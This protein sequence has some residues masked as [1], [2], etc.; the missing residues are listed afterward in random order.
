MRLNNRSLSLCLAV[1]MLLAGC[2][3]TK[4]ASTATFSPIQPTIVF[5]GETCTYYGPQTIPAGKLTVDWI[6]KD[7]KHEA[8]GLVVATLKPDK[9][10]DDLD[11]WP[12]ADQPPWLNVVGYSEAS[13]DS[14]QQEIYQITEGPIYYVCFYRPPDTK[15]GVTRS[16]AVEG[17]SVAA[18]VPTITPHV[19]PT[20]AVQPRPV[21]IDTDMGWD[22]EVA[23]LY[24]LQRA[25]ISVQAITVSGTGL[26]H[27]NPG[28]E[29]ASG[30]ATLA[31]YADMPVACGRETPLEGAHAFPDDWRTAVDSL[32]G[33]GMNVPEGKNPAAGETA[34]SLLTAAI[35]SLP[36]KATVLLLGP[37]TNLAD[38]LQNYPQA[39]NNIEA[40]YAMGGAVHVAGN[41][42]AVVPANKA[43]EW[44][45][46]IDPHA[47]QIVFESGIPV[48]LVPL[49]ATNQV[50]VTA[51]FFPLTQAS[52]LT[53]EA[54]WVF[55]LFSAARGHLLSGGEY[56]WDPLTAAI[57]AGEGLA[58]YEQNTLCVVEQEG[59]QSGQIVIK[60][61]CPS[62]RVAVK[63]EY[64][65]FVQ[66]LLDTLNNP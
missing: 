21:F 34:V 5:D 61:G 4:D 32:F 55:D 38:L 56:F 23:I 63:A 40:I 51:D 11:S 19:A 3:Q 18:L 37:M 54:T 48:I 13:P 10:F 59:P 62:T 53:P 28:V 65:A 31:G 20:Q 24:L 58:T 57:L 14:K 26:T 1:C 35:S 52:H 2:K 64:A 49:D 60:A 6:V 44:N 12:G 17:G 27:C 41:L 33:T 7:K 22:D 9:T 16:I 66:E 46:Y 25:D 15:F 39:K 36:Q 50:P 47:A 43:A 30:L 45:I 29:N 8:Y 42:G